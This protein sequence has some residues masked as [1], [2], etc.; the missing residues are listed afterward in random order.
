MK[1]RNN[2]GE[3]EVTTEVITV[4]SV[5]HDRVRGGGRVDSEV[6]KGAVERDE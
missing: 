4:V 1:G 2:V 6:R 3:K 5:V